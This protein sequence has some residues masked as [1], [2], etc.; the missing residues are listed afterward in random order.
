MRWNGR[1]ELGCPLRGQSLESRLAAQRSVLRIVRE[2]REPGYLQGPV[3]GVAKVCH[4][5]AHERPRPTNAP[6]LNRVPLISRGAGT[7]LSNAPIQQM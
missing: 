3:Q 4:R 1:G 2:S 6:V 5:T 7:K